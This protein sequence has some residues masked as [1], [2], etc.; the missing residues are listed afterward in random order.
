MFIGESVSSVRRPTLAV[1]AGISIA[2]I[3]SISPSAAADSAPL[4]VALIPADG[5]TADGT[6]ADFQ[7]VFDAVAAGAGLQF[8]LSVGQSYN[9]V[10]E[11]VCNR[12]ADLAF[13]GPVSYVQARRRGC[14]EL[15]AV[16]VENGASTYYAGIFATTE[17]PINA[18]TDIKGRR[19]AF[20][21][22]NSASS[23]VFPVAMLLDAGIDPGADLGQV[24]LTG[25][26][27]NSLAALVQGRVDAAG[28]SFESFEKAV[29][30]GV[31]DPEKVKIVARSAPI[32][33]PPL[34][35]STALP[36]ET[37]K[38]LK[39]AFGDVA[40]LPG[41]N[42]DMIRGYG[43][44]RIQ[45]YDAAFAEDRFAVAAEMMERVDDRVRSEL[46][47]KATDR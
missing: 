28:L 34:A 32:P 3:L 29:M 13:F 33:N 20:G 6:L 25:S 14:A 15:L 17:G 9:A 43:G 10:V 26:H 11:A 47:R 44:R 7:P 31:A 18:L 27:T 24:Q 8:R 42:P 36:A 45:G 1:V 23:F 37:K 22:V 46:L 35:M 41:V 40:S 4:E 38:K 2:Y 19:I 12:T 30:Q 21:D 16:A 5:G 39:A